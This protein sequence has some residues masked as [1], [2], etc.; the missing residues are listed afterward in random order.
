MHLKSIH[1]QAAFTSLP[2]KVKV[3]LLCST[4]RE[5]AVIQKPWLLR[6]EIH[7]WTQNTHRQW[8]FTSEPLSLYLAD[9]QKCSKNNEK[10]KCMWLMQ[11]NSFS[12]KQNEWDSKKSRYKPVCQDWADGGGRIASGERENKVSKE[13][14]LSQ[15]QQNQFA[16]GKSQSEDHGC[17]PEFSGKTVGDWARN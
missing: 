8:G 13:H 7:L 12:K 16:L 14:E 9:I 17:S 15:G 2:V 4:N 6:C 1:K 11:R 3:E 10:E 5:A